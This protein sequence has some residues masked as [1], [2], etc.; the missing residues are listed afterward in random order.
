VEEGRPARRVTHGHCPMALAGATTRDGGWG[1]GEGRGGEGKGGEGVAWECAPTGERYRINPVLTMLSEARS[2]LSSHRT[3]CPGDA[4]D[5]WNCRSR[6]RMCSA[7]R[8]VQQVVWVA[9]GR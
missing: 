7:A 6:S 9:G 1:G 5:S 4:V 3:I 2:P 8:P